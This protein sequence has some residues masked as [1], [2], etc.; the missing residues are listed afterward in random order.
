LDLEFPVTRQV[1]RIKSFA[2]EE[3]ERLLLRDRPKEHRGLWPLYL[4][5]LDAILDKATHRQ[6]AEVFFPVPS[7]VSPQGD[8]E[9]L[10]DALEQ[11]GRL[12]KPGTDLRFLYLPSQD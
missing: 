7:E 3:R 5:V 11:A 2:I 1:E 12:I 8:I 4:R 6:M 10:K 9:K